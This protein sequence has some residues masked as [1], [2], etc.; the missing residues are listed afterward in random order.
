MSKEIITAYKGFDENWQCLGFQYEVGKTYKHDGK[1][2]VCSS[3]FHSCTNPFD[4][5][6]YYDVTKNF[7]L[8]ELNGE[9]QNHNSDSKIASAEIT[10]KTELKLP[11]FISSCIKYL[12]DICGQTEQS[13]DYSQLAASG[14][15]SQLVAS[16]DYSKLAASG[17][18]S[19]LVASGDYSKLAAS[20]VC[21]QLAASGNHSQLA[22]SGNYS[23]LAASGNY[24]KLAASGDCSQL[25][26]SGNHSKLA[27][28]GNYSKLAASGDYSVVVS[29]GIISIAKC[30]KNGA[31]AL[32]RWVESEKRYR[33][34]V[35]HEGEGIKADTWYALDDD[36]NFV[37]YK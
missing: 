13:G 16:G 12:Q 6:N 15:H 19:Q 20:G 25:A 4:V 29:S 30:G 28:S 36:G 37:E 1:V 17:N 11:D 14:N 27:A 23:K 24:S 3:G 10:I 22:A 2:E 33:I 32:T 7:A 8:V 21:S 18:Y 31:I 5:L 35:A 34:S 26:V 9:T